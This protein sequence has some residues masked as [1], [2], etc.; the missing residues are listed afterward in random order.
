[1][2]DLVVGVADIEDCEKLQKIVEEFGEV[3]D[4]RMNWHKCE[5]LGIGG[6]IKEVDGIQEVAEGIIGKYV[7]KGEEVRYL[8]IWF[9]QLG[10]VLRTEWWEKW[11]SSLERSLVGW[12][13]LG[14]SLQGKVVV[15]NGY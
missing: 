12:G 15:L 2:D 6:W 5:T 10:S 8:G 7:K 14:L 9:S 4:G 13:G 3:S 1:M 11:V